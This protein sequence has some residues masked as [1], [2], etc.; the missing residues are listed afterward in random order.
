MVVATL[1]TAIPFMVIM[2]LATRPTAILHTE[3]MVIIPPAT[4]IPHME[5]TAPIQLMVIQAM[6]VTVEHVP[7]TDL[8]F[9]AIR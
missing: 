1:V 7:V 8:G 2:A 9:I 4:A 6:V 5:V 3:V